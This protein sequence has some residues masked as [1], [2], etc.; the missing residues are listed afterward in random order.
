[1][2]ETKLNI[3]DVLKELDRCNLTYYRNLSDEEKKSLSLW[4][5]TR[6]MSSSENHKEHHLLMVNDLVNSGASDL[7]NH[8]ELQWMSLCICGIGSV[9]K[10]KWVA[11][12]KKP[13]KD[14]LFDAVLNMYPHLKD[15]EVE[16]MCRLL[17]NDEIRTLFKDFGMDDKEI[18]E[19]IK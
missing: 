16:M 8:P 9:S 13:K 17:S 7:K 6:W 18:K 4:V 14:K 12:P 3:F 10:H 5:L 11:P 19:L 2:K 15:D 1:M